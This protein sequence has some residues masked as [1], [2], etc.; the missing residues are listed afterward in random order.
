MHRTLW[1]VVTL[2]A[3]ASTLAEERMA[4]G[5]GRIDGTRIAPYDFNWQQ[6]MK[7]DGN[8]TPAGSVAETLAV[9]GDHVLRH[10]QRTTQPG[11]PVAT[12]TTYFDRAS[13]APLRIET[14]V[15]KDGQQLAYAERI[16]ESEGYSGFME[17]GDQRVELAGKISSNMLHGM[18]MGLPLAAMDAPDKPVRFLASMVSFDGTYDVIASWVGTEALRVGDT[19]ATA[20]QVDVEWH[21]RESG[22]IY[23]PGPD[24]SG[25]RYW[26]VPEPPSGIPYVPR[27]Q[28]DTYVVDFRSCET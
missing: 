9:I 17:K 4:I 5:D 20:H 1:V 25:G 8:W 26:I 2:V 10:R 6:C 23:L 24:A 22:D 3:A 12:T 21:H 19:H 15:V 27:Y 16:L 14:R 18:V 7:Q 11:G 13:F 28:T